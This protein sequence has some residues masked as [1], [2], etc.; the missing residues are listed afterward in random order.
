M[1]QKENKWIVFDDSLLHEAWN[2]SDQD[3]YVLIIDFSVDRGNKTLSLS[4][5]V[6]QFETCNLTEEVKSF[7]KIYYGFKL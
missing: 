4:N 1:T 3:R 2:F 5:N 6:I 7:L